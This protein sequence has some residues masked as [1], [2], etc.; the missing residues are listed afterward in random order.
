MIARLLKWVAAPLVLAAV[1]AV[2]ASAQ[3]CRNSRYS[4]D[5]AYSTYQDSGYYDSGYYDR[6]YH[7]RAYVHVSLGHVISRLLGNDHRYERRDHRRSYDSHRYEQR[8]DR[9]DWRR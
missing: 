6:G 4:D 7:G 8:H 2:P 3:E 1:A 9:R 5:G